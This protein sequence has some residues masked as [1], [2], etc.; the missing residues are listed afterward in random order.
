[1]QLPLHHKCAHTHKSNK[2]NQIKVGPK[3]KMKREE[4]GESTKP[5][6]EQIDSN[7]FSSFPDCN[8]TYYGNL[9][10]TY[11]MELHRPKEDKTPFVCQL[12]FTAAGG[13]HGDIVQV[14]VGF[15]RAN[16]HSNALRKDEKFKCDDENLKECER[17]NAKKQHAAI[18]T[19]TSALISSS[20]KL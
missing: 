6:Q 7:F 19:I 5:P 8:R 2:I 10:V 14:R 15:P 13:M 20:I 4:D 12:T 16:T 1:M 9:G 18:V 17:H 11:H 3:I